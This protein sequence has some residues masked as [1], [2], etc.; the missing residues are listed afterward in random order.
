MLIARAKVPLEGHRVEVSLQK[1]S[2]GFYGWFRGGEHL[3]FGG[4]EGGV[5]HLDKAKAFRAIRRAYPDADT[6][7]VFSESTGPAKALTVRQPWA[8][9]IAEGKKTLEIRSRLTHYRGELLICSAAS[10]KIEPFGQA[11]CIV[12]VVGVKPFEPEDAEA[13]CT[14]WEPDSFAWILENPRPIEL[15]P[16]KGQLGFYSVALPEGKAWALEAK[17]WN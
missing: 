11:L 3:D 17:P 5:W 7:E 15:F 16:V 1:N 14:D 2:E 6:F 10:P 12:D 9:L 13:A 8:S 4:R